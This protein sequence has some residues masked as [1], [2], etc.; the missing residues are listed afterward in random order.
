[1]LNNKKERKKGL[2]LYIA[3]GVRRSIF[4]IIIINTTT[5]SP[6]H[7]QALPLRIPADAGGIA[8]LYLKNDGA[9]IDCRDGRDKYA[10]GKFNQQLHLFF[11][12]IK[13]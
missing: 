5:S 3:L 9:A 4:P 12:P 8:I 11:L 2:E 6:W 7:E 1:M 10:S 13:K